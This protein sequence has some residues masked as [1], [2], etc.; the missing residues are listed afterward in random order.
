IL[1][2]IPLL[3]WET[4][5]A[6][7]VGFEV[8]Q[9]I[10]ERL[11]GPHVPRFIANGD[12]AVQP[13]IAMEDIQGELLANKLDALPLAAEEVARV[14]TKLAEALYE[15]HRQHVIHLDVKP[16][17]VILRHSGEAALIDFGLSRHEELPDL[18]EEEFNLPMGTAQYM[19]PEQALRIRSD[20]RSD[21]FATGVVLYQLAT[22]VLPFGEPKN[23]KGVRRRLWRDP[24]PPRAHVGSI[25]DWLQEIVLRCLEPLPQNRYDSAAQ[26]LFDLRRAAEIALTERAHRLK[27]SGFAAVL[28][29][30]LGAGKIRSAI[31]HSL[32]R[33][34]ARAPIVVVA[35][36]LR[37]GLE[38]LREALRTAARLA[39]ESAPGARLAC[40]NVTVTSLVKID[41]QADEQGRNIHVQKLV[42]L[43]HWAHPMGLP[44]ERLTYHVLQSIDAVAALIDYARTNRADN[45]ILGAPTYSGRYLGKVTSQIVAEAPCSVTVVRANAEI[46][47]WPAPRSGNGTDTRR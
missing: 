28:R 35:V 18:L 32:S 13:Y 7:I 26:L 6:A 45:I 33:Q 12:F 24:T 44:A 36:D 42:E 29:R 4:Q 43:K 10:L 11:A 21:I 27:R 2:K 15:V 5:P 14:G 31:A 30:R 16:G 34:L 37:P 41:P 1:M 46:G 39:L 25:P 23:A 8:E 17:N 3:D 19:A 9:M 38:D 47:Y 20:S 22:G 40:V